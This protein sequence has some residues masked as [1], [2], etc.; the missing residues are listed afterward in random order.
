[1]PVC[2]AVL[3]IG[4][5]FANRGLYRINHTTKKPRTPDRDRTD[6]RCR[7]RRRGK[8]ESSW[9]DQLRTLELQGEFD[10]FGNLELGLVAF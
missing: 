10:R 9:A 6:A 8:V 1:M 3:V 7:P 5:Y 4:R 2:A